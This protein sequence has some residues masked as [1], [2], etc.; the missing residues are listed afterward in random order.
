MSENT[1]CTIGCTPLLTT[2]L[3]IVLIVISIK[4]CN[5]MDDNLEE[6]VNEPYEEVIIKRPVPQYTID[7]TD[8]NR[9]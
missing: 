7:L 8:T 1:G 6:V 2:V 3:L 9:L 5:R 4:H